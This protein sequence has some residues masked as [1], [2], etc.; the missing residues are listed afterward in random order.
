MFTRDSLNKRE[1]RPYLTRPK[2]KNRSLRLRVNV[3][4]IFLRDFM[5]IMKADKTLKSNSKEPLNST[6]CRIR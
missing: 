6:S 3:A 4:Q 1:S 5:E 2:R